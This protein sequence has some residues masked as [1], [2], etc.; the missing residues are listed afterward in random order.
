MILIIYPKKK[1]LL[2]NVYNVQYYQ[3][4]LIL[5]KYTLFIVGAAMMVGVV[6]QDSFSDYGAQCAKT[7]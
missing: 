6:T 1:K 7:G 2:Q 4:T 5:S 3:T